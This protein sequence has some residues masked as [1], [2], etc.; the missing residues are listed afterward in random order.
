LSFNSLVNTVPTTLRGLQHL[1]LVHLHGNRLWGSMPALNTDTLKAT[2]SFIS[3]CGAPSDLVESLTCPNC[4]ICCNSLGDCHKADDP[5]GITSGTIITIFGLFVVGY[6]VAVIAGAYVYEYFKPPAIYPTTVQDKK[7]ARDSIG[8]DSVYQYILSKSKYGQVFAL[9]V[10]A[11][12]VWSLSIFVMVANKDFDDDRSD[13]VYSW[14]C[15]KDS[16]DCRDDNDYSWKGWTLFVFL[17]AAHLLKD[18]INGLKLLILCGQRRHAIHARIFYFTGGVF[19]TSISLYTIFASTMYNKA[20][21]R[22]DSGLLANAV[23]IMFVVD[24]DEYFF[25]AVQAAK[26]GMRGNGIDDEHNGDLAA[27]VGQLE[28]N[29]TTQVAEFERR[30]RNEEERNAFL[31][32]RVQQL[33]GQVQGHINGRQS[34]QEAQGSSASIEQLEQV[35]RQVEKLHDLFHGAFQ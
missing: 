14:K 25:Q 21:G 31:Q 30:L 23:I 12:Q 35:K 8:R 16:L 27:R 22:S 24:V 29:L 18:L 20:I 19:L 4:T 2:S 9:V 5:E 11:C 17:M 7:Y 6:I 33:E 32:N 15:Q 10:V 3:D 28:S 34:T 1:E 13:Y 26:A